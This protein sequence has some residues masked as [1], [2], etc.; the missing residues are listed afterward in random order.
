M[1]STP[2]GTVLASDGTHF[3]AADLVFHLQERKE[4][5]KIMSSHSKK[6]SSYREPKPYLAPY[7]ARGTNRELTA[8]SLQNEQTFPAAAEL[9][10]TQATS[11]FRAVRTGPMPLTALTFTEVLYTTE[12]L[13]VNNEYDTATGNFIPQNSGLYSFHASVEFF[14]TTT[15]QL[16]FIQLLL[17]VNDNPVAD[18]FDYFPGNEGYTSVSAIVDL[19][20]GDVVDVM[21]RSGVAGTINNFSNPNQVRFEGVRIN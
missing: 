14:P 12:R 11:A 6:R 1:R 5:R 2:A 13:D 10:I 19:Q 9:D 7:V 18:A 3:S 16:Y 15:G 21:A 17:R 4:R 20:A 8:S